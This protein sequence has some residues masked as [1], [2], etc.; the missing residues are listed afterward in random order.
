[1]KKDIHPE[2]MDC[3][4]TCACGETFTVKSTKPEINV[5]NFKTVDVITT[6]ADGGMDE[7]TTRKNSTPYIPIP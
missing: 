2:V 5:E 7:P 4:V 3:T 1:M 6:S